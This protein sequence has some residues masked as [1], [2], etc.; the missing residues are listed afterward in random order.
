[1][2]SSKL[3]GAED[4]GRRREI[5]RTSVAHREALV[6]TDAH[7]DRLASDVVGEVVVVD[8]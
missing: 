1:V 2:L 5:E 8:A 3:A 7:S 4:D 6:G